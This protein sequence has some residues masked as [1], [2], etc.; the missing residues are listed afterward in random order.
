MRDG[1]HIGS[2]RLRSKKS[3]KSET[4]SWPGSQK[5]WESKK[6]KTKESETQGKPGKLTPFLELKAPHA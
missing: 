2:F 1:T 3:A 4:S 6:R 5:G